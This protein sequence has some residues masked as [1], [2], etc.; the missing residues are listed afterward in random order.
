[1]EAMAATLGPA[2]GLPIC[3][4]FLRPS[5]SGRI[6]PSHQLLSIST[7]PFFKIFFQ[8]APLAQGVVAGLG[9]FASGRD[10]LADFH[11]PQFQRRHERRALAL[12]QGL[13]FHRPQAGLPGF[14]FHRVKLADAFDD[15]RRQRVLRRQF[16]RFDKAPPGMGHATG[17]DDAFA[18]F[19][20]GAVAVALQLAAKT[21]QEL[22]R[23]FPSAP[24]LKV[25]HDRSARLAEFPNV[26][27][28]VAPGFFARLHRHGGFIGLQ[29]GTVYAVRPLAPAPP[30][31][32]NP[33][34]ARMPA[35][36]VLRLRSMPWLSASTAHCR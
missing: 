4:Q 11:Q 31:A 26:G 22:F 5:A 21:S 1:M 6:A 27:P 12:A 3:S 7:R 29:I 23:A 36:R 34:A 2:S 20:I 24:H 28:V 30:R 16:G 25:E 14:F 18:Q 9:Q 35:V 15:F 8:P 13:A 10:L 33:P 32:N 19:V 17:I